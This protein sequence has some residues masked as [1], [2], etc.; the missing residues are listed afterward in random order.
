MLPNINRKNSKLTYLKSLIYQ[1][2]M[3]FDR[4]NLFSFH[5]IATYEKYYFNRKLQ[6]AP[7]IDIYKDKNVLSIE[8]TIKDRVVKQTTRDFKIGI[9]LNTFV[10]KIVI[11]VLKR[12]SN[13]KRVRSILKVST[14]I[15]LCTYSVFSS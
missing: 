11:I 8:V 12:K 7:Y 4:V 13:D 6:K 15:R 5:F 10:L 2:E 3:K 14:E 1:K 9:Y